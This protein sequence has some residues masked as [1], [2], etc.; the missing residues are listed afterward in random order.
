[1]PWMQFPA[2][3]VEEFILL[4]TAVATTA[5]SLLAY[6]TWVLLKN[7]SLS[8]YDERKRRIHLSPMRNSYSLKLARLNDEMT[9]TEQRWSD[10]NHLLVSAQNLQ[11]ND[12]LSEIVDTKI[13]LRNLGIDVNKITIDPHMIFVLTPFEESEMDAFLRIKDICLKNDFNC[14]RGDEKFISGDIFPHIVEMIIRARL[15]IANIGTRNPNVYYELGIAQSLGKKTILVSH[16]INDTPF[17]IKS[18][19]IV[20]YRNQEDLEKKL[21]ATLLRAIKA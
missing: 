20:I 21:T 2:H 13:F 10:A 7:K 9:A 16:T 14:I 8:Q 5:T 11:R 15:I 1:M 12:P 6:A 4:S 17:D 19:Q 18:Q 3:W